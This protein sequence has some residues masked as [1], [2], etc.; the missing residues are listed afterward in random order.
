MNQALSIE[1]VKDNLQSAEIPISP[2]P[3][4]VLGE[5]PVLNRGR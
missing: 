5:D 4:L 1:N 2:G 3:I